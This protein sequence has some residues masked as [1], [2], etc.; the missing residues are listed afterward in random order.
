MNLFRIVQKRTNK[1]ERNGSPYRDVLTV[2]LF[3]FLLPYVI[4]CLWGHI[5]EETEVLFQK[6]KAEETEYIDEEYEVTL[7]GERGAKHVSMQEYLI[8]KL[9]VVMPKEEDGK[10]YEPEALKA[11]AILLRT[12]LWSLFLSGEDAVVLQDDISMYEREETYTQEEEQLYT[13]AVLA[14]DGIFLAYNGQPVKAAFFPVSN[15]QTRN[16]DEVLLS[17]SYPYLIR[18]E[19]KQDILAKEYQSQVSVTKEEYCLAVRELFQ[20]ELASAEIWEHLK[21]TYDSSDYVIKAEINGSSCSGETFRYTFGLASA[22]FWTEW[23]E[24]SVTFHVKGVGHGF[25]M[26][27]YGANEKAVSGDTFDQILEDYFFQAELVKIE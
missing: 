10:M 25:G 27:Q 23:E 4:S 21:L 11:Q 20:T 1:S 16:A 18:V 19:C 6:K 5:G 13:E 22:D 2:L 24:D 7:V 17:E 15:G 8:R 9:K 3:V 12:E 26:S 14:T